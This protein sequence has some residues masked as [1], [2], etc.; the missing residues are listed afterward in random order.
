MAIKIN[1]LPQSYAL[2][3]RRNQVVA[4]MV[5]LLA[6]T[7]LGIGLLYASD[8]KQL[9]TV[10]QNADAVRSVAAQTAAANTARDSAIAA[11]SSVKNMVDFMAD[12]SKSGPERAAFLDLFR[13]YIFQGALISDLDVSSGTQAVMKARVSSPDDYARFLNALRLGAKAATDAPVGGNAAGAGKIFDSL[14]VASGVRGFP[15]G[16]KLPLAPDFSDTPTAIIPPVDV[17]AQGPLRSDPNPRNSLL[18]VPAEPPGTAS[19]AV[20]QGAGGSAGGS[21]GSS[22]YPGSS[23]SSYPGSSGARPSAS[24]AR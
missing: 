24:P 4:G 6:L 16:R 7:G 14:P 10:K 3:K 19:A 5:G 13:R 21:S 8:K 22:S 12:A 15:E 20:A 23:S 11:A 17:T 1:L 18:Y 2:E 9:E